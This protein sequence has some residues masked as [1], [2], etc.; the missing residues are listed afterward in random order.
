MKS[1]I[2]SLVVALISAN[3]IAQSASPEFLWWEGRYFGYEF[4]REPVHC[5]MRL[6][7][8]DEY[9]QHQQTA[10]NSGD[11]ISC[12][13]EIEYLGSEQGFV[14][15]V[16]ASADAGFIYDGLDSYVEEGD[17]EARLD[18]EVPFRIRRIVDIQYDGQ[19]GAWISVPTIQW[20][21]T[22]DISGS[23]AVN[24]NEGPDE[25]A[26]ISY[27]QL[28]EGE[29]DN[30][31]GEWFRLGDWFLY[32]TNDPFSVYDDGRSYFNESVTSAVKYWPA[33]E[34]EA[35]DTI[36]LE[37]YACPS[38]VPPASMPHFSA[39][40]CTAP[41]QVLLLETSPF[42]DSAGVRAFVRATSGSGFLGIIDGGEAI[43]CF[44]QESTMANFG[45]FGT[46]CN[47]GG[48]SLRVSITETD[49]VKYRVTRRGLGVW[50]VVEPD[51]ILVPTLRPVT[52]VCLY[53]LI[54]LLAWMHVRRHR[55][56]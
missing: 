42:L 12:T 53:T 51:A 55:S 52:Y 26:S 3:A 38:F 40:L 28:K 1:L 9:T 15:R 48:I 22:Y 29:V 8:P 2:F 30:G 10:Y 54:L 6:P 24:G 27:I 18:Y 31:I 56:R 25:S 45:S 17:V 21:Y 39:A 41:D 32:F 23:V 13:G 47:S 19:G 37:E 35:G 11:V 44:G 50:K 49:R 43:G 36:E 14:A 20:S 7:D 34:L 46:S 4:P 5:L 33:P 16:E